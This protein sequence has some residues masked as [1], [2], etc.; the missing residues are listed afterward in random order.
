[1]RKINRREF[2]K[3]SRLDEPHAL[4]I[5]GMFDSGPLMPGKLL[6]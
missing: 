6:F 3:Y 4:F 1:M 5:P 2:I